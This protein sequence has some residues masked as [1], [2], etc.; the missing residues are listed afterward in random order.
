[1]ELETNDKKEI[2]MGHFKTN[3]TRAEMTQPA[4]LKTGAQIGELVNQ[5]AYRGDLV[6]YLGPGAGGP[7]PAAYNPS[8]SEIEVNTEAAFGK[9]VEAEV[10]GDLRERDTQFEWPRASGAIFHE[11]CHARYSRWSMEAAH[12]SLSSSE[13]E[14]LQLLE[15]GRIEGLGVHST[16]SNREFLRSCALEIVLGDLSEEGLS[17]I[18]TIHAGA[19]L[20]GLTLARVDAGVLEESDLGDVPQLL[21]TLLGADLLK[22]LRGLWNEMQMHDDH[23]DI[24]PMYD[25][26]RRWIEAIRTAQTEKGEETQ[27]SVEQQIQEI[28]EALAD[29][30]GITE[31]AAAGELAE[32]QI[33]EQWVKIAKGRSADSSEEHSHK[34]IAEKIFTENAEAEAGSKTKSTLASR[35]QPTSQERAAA[36]K[37]G[38]LFDKAKYRERSQT[39]IQSIT[40][41][42]RLRTRALVQGAA[43]KSKGLLTQTEPWRRTQRKHTDNPQ[44]KVGVMVDISGSMGDAMEPMAVTAWVLSEATKRVQGRAAMV[45]YG[46]DVF[47]TLKPGQSLPEVQVYTA[48]DGTEKFDKA[49]KALDGAMNF[50]HGD[51]ARMLVVVSDGHYT[52]EET[53]AATKWVERCYKAGVGVLWLTY[54]DV[55][56]ANRWVNGN[57]EVVHVGKDTVDAAQKIGMAAVK[58][59]SKA[60]ASR[61]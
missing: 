50:L 17:K 6:V 48:P 20:A 8:L 58:V 38:Q 54:D 5:W 18:S 29:A 36:V 19:R 61:R 15:E 46:N 60:S 33:S 10:V 22:T 39:E 1:M 43:L 40:P 55:V 45:Y 57:G 27:E 44:L 28:L 31:I 13:F 30:A 35:R 47:P 42:G 3:G 53:Q 32:Q 9:G 52:H 14:A 4:W 37:L 7:A 51:G 49:F 34:G 41:P 11:A 21:E 2:H 16:P 59:L 26:A 56:Q 23:D 24:T 12:G 25:V